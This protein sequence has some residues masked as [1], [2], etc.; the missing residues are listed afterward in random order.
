MRRGPIHTISIYRSFR[1]AHSYSRPPILRG[2]L[3]PTALVLRSVVHATS[4]ATT[5]PS[6]TQMSSPQPPPQ[7]VASQSTPNLHLHPV[8]TT[9]PASN[10]GAP[11]P[12]VV[13]HILNRGLNPALNVVGPPRSFSYAPMTR[14]NFEKAYF[15][16]WMPRHPIG[17]SMHQVEGRPIDL[18]QLHSEVISQNGYWTSI[19]QTMP[20]QDPQFAAALVVSQDQ[21][22]VI[23]ERLGFVNVNGNDLEPARSRPNVAIDIERVYMQ[24]LW[25]FD[26]EYL[27]QLFHHR[28]RI[29]LMRQAIDGDTVGGPSGATAPGSLSDIRDPQEPNELIHWAALPVSELQARGVPA[30]IIAL[31]QAHRDRL[32]STPQQQQGFAENVRIAAQGHP[33][34]VWDSGM[35]YYNP[36]VPPQAG[37]MNATNHVSDLPKLPVQPDHPQQPIDVPLASTSSANLQQP[38][39]LDGAPGTLSLPRH[40]PA[41]EQMA[42]ALELVRRLKEENQRKSPLYQLWL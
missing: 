39:H 5:Q 31:V 40:R 24:C 38:Q 14:E 4:I 15:Q 10:A 22:R 23:A 19:R 2:L 26:R 21:W 6:N 17:R 33:W 20:G 32:N 37:G 3:N 27:R 41:S 12:R 18:Y 9:I 42:A 7:M 8:P 35:A 25:E 34:N 29:A 11:P 36:T 1:G 16:H 13:Q 30:N 28:R